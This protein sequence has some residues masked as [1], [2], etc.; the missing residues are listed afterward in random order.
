M[1]DPEEIPEN[2]LALSAGNSRAR[3]GG[4]NLYRN[5]RRAKLGGKAVYKKI[6]A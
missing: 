6:L 5:S 2:I 4:R 1:P 3:T